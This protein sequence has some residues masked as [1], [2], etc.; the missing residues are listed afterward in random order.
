MSEMPITAKE[1]RER[2]NLH[3]D[4]AM[5]RRAELREMIQA[6]QVSAPRQH[7]I[8]RATTDQ[9]LDQQLGTDK[10]W[11]NNVNDN[12]WWLA[13]ATAFGATESAQYLRHIAIQNAQIIK[14]LKEIRD[15]HRAASSVGRH[16]TFNPAG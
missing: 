2:A 16:T 11:S 14:L 1:A 3:R 5:R 7:S 9:I 12:K 4:R 8:T 15:D 6:R 13:Q 10:I